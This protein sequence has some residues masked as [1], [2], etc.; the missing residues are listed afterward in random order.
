MASVSS[1]SSLK[2]FIG[3]TEG[4]V[5]DHMELMTNSQ[6]DPNPITSMVPAPVEQGKFL[7]VLFISEISLHFFFT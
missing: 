6:Q 4:A 3:A 7:T 2:L 1:S 5:A